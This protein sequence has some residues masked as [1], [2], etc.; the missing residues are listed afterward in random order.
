[1]TSLRIGL[2]GDNHGHWDYLVAACSVLRHAHDCSAVIQVGDC[3]LASETMERHRD[4]RFPFPVYVV[5]GNHE[6]HAL[7]RSLR[8]ADPKED[9]WAH[10][11]MQWMRRG[12]ILNLGGR[13]IGWCGG[14][15]HSDAEQETWPATLPWDNLPMNTDH[16]NYP[17][18]GNADRLLD[19]LQGQQLDLLITHSCP[20]GIGIGMQPRPA[21][22]WPME[23][24]V[25]SRGIDPG[26]EDDEGEPA[27]RHLWSQL[28]TNRPPHWIHGHWHT[29][30]TM[31]IGNTVFTCLPP[32]DPDWGS[33]RPLWMDTDTLA[34]GSSSPI[35]TH[36]LL[37]LD[38]A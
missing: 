19:R 7:L 16:A 25:R 38:H 36:T 5:D 20:A 13:T 32:C 30:R 12:E 34:I 6:D 11:G 22:R 28:G 15:L 23:V 8:D 21:F 4:V 9:P 33:W 1:M 18:L 31:A 10:M 27:L 2:L 24:H 29:W 37:S 3:G 26:P 35:P 14:A 17:L